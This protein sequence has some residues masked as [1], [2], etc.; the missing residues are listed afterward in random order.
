MGRKSHSL[1]PTWIVG[2]QYLQQAVLPLAWKG[3]PI[4]FQKEASGCHSDPAGTQ[5]RRKAVLVSAKSTSHFL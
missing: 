4:E 2:V 5:S 3:L 1:H